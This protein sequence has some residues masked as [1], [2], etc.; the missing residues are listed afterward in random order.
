MKIPSAGR[1]L[2][3]IPLALVLFVGGTI[4]GIWS[5][6]LFDQFLANRA[7]DNLCSQGHPPKVPL[8]SLSM[9]Y[10]LPSTTPFYTSVYASMSI[11][12]P[13][14]DPDF[15][16]GWINAPAVIRAY[17]PESD[18]GSSLSNQW[19]SRHYRTRECTVQIN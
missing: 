17:V 16:R 13:V 11:G 10:F 18:I 7:F 2:F 5:V 15:E 4:G 1:F 12:S 8:D 14:K 3:L 9:R 19:I 6:R